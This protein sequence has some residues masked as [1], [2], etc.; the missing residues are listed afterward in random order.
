MY[1]YQVT[2]LLGRLNDTIQE[3]L[4]AKS[5]SI[6]D[7]LHQELLFHKAIA[8]TLAESLEI[9]EAIEIGDTDLLFNRSRLFIN[10]DTSYITFINTKGLVLARG[11]DELRFGDDL[12][13]NPLVKKVLTGSKGSFLGNLE[14]KIYLLAFHPI[15]K[16]GRKIVGAVCVGQP[17][18]EVLQKIASHHQV[19]ISVWQQNNLL[20]AS[21]ENLSLT[22]WDSNSIAF[23]VNGQNNFQLDVFE[24]NIQ[25]RYHLV[26][27]R[28]NLLTIFCFVSVTLVL[29]IL[30]L[31]RRLLLPV[32]LLVKNML[33]YSTNKEL[34]EVPQ[35][36][37]EIGDLVRT[38]QQMS[39]ELDKNKSSI[40]KF[41]TEL[42]NEVKQRRKAEKELLIANETLEDNVRK[43]TS[44]LSDAN[45]KLRQ[46]LEE[47]NT[48]KGILPICCSCK[49]IRDDEGYW[50]QVEH[51]ITEHSRATFSHGICP[52]CY[53]E[54]MKKIDKL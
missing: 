40:E 12:Y 4:T 46:A 11:H 28:N 31:V 25:Q 1:L 10:T 43:R 20:G 13:G 18:N 14:G 22:D 38:F 19:V 29:L 2:D 47:I 30:Y 50:Q 9:A 51:Y 17:L 27:N 21:Q 5:I 37:N 15:L 39:I 49:K 35:P 54:E 6:Q 8:K 53:E 32:N 24:N 48:L 3:R 45:S 41:N 26:K 23:A 36:R 42:H 16:R 52:A 7:N 34:L 44:E 33:S